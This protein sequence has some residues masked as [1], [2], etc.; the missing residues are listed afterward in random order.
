M[1]AAMKRFWDWANQ[2]VKLGKQPEPVLEPIPVLE[3]PNPPEHVMGL[4]ESVT[5]LDLNLSETISA[6]DEL[7]VPLQAAPAEP[8]NPDDYLGRSAEDVVDGLERFLQAHA[9]TEASQV[10]WEHLLDEVKVIKIKRMRLMDLE[11]ECERIRGELQEC[12]KNLAM[13]AKR[14]SAEESLTISMHEKRLELARAVTRRI[15][16]L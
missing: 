1:A 15:D 16:G 8:T 4:P 11:I 14:A 13:Q 2:P 5:G 9:I 10:S 12:K 3:V 7:D 6:N